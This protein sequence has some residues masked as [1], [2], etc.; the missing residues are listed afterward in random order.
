VGAAAYARG[1]TVGAETLIPRLDQF[2]ALV[3]YGSRQGRARC[4]ERGMDWSDLTDDERQQ[5]IDELLHEE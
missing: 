3:D 2:E 1:Q 4:A 5:F